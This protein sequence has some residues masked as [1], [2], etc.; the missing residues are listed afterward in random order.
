MDFWLEDEVDVSQ[1]QEQQHEQQAPLSQI[2]SQRSSLLDQSSFQCEHCGGVDFYHDDATGA[3]ICCSCFTQSQQ[4]QS[5]PEG[6]DDIEDILQ[7]AAKSRGGGIATRRKSR[8]STNNEEDGDCYGMLSQH[9]RPLSWFDTS[10]ELPD[11]ATCLDGLR[12]IVKV[13]LRILTEDILNL[14][15]LEQA[16]SNE[17]AR[18]IFVS[19]VQS[20]GEGAEHYGKMYPDVRFSLRD[21]F[22][23]GV[24]RGGLYAVLLDKAINQVKS[25][26]IDKDNN[27]EDTKDGQDGNH[28]NPKYNNAE[29]TRS[30]EMNKSI[31]HDSSRRSKSVRKT[32]MQL[33]RRIVDQGSSQQQGGLKGP[34]EAA[35]VIQPGLT[36][37]T[38]LL[39][40]TVVRRGVSLIQIRDW[41]WNRNVLPLRNAFDQ[42]LG[43]EQ[44]HR[45]KPIQ[46]NLRMIAMPTNHAL[47]SYASL[48]LVAAGVKAHKNENLFA[49][50]G[51][52][53]SAMQQRNKVRIL[54]Q[55]AIQMITAQLVSDV[56]LTQSVLDTALAL[57]GYAPT[58]EMGY[59]SWLPAKIPETLVYSISHI[60][61]VVFCAVELQPNWREFVV[62]RNGGTRK[63]EMSSYSSSLL[64]CTSE[65]PWTEDRFRSM[66][67]GESL[68]GYL[69]FCEDTFAQCI[70]KSKSSIPETLGLNSV[71]MAAKREEE[72]HKHDEIDVE[73]ESIRPCLL[74]AGVPL[75]PKSNNK[76][77]RRSSL[78][79][80]R[81][82]ELA[83][84]N[85]NRK[86]TMKTTTEAL[87]HLDPQERL[88]L[89]FL[90]YSTQT[91]CFKIKRALGEI[92]QY[93]IIEK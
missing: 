79:Q 23:P 18:Q 36:M 80:E 91:C 9:R 54:S 44:Q 90:A 21:L 76:K 84:R 53:L 77:S 72:I 29:L 89:E 58:A 35:L 28:N 37:V 59:S 15:P 57:L 41:I 10:R 81:V 13:S 6:G 8:K 67:S 63:Q 64:S 75:A 82:W 11:L 33:L 92:L 71:D 39:W 25:E 56:G 73:C 17:I 55:T 2:S 61:A 83:R 3:D 22:L 49:G 14:D 34:R 32:Y 31:N 86:R 16:K 46:S 50:G 78:L 12:Q 48:L 68:D 62:V 87:P 20:W 88:L 52:T 43:E 93:S 4:R 69:K 74:V 30:Q 45:L 5:Q 24:T 66:S 65:I 85:K 47:E 7:V 19:Y 60:A 70:R 26:Q 1:Q 27:D 42:C 38:A 51:A 40:L